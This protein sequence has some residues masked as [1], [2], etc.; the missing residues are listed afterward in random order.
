MAS[1]TWRLEHAIQ[2]GNWTDT[3]AVVS[4]IAPRLVGD[5]ASSSTPLP[6][7]APGS[8]SNSSTHNQ[9]HPRTSYSDSN[10]S[11]RDGGDPNLQPATRWT[12]GGGGITG[13]ERNVFVLSGGVPLLLQIFSDPGFTQRHRT[14]GQAESNNTSTTS[15][16]NLA[17]RYTTTGHISPFPTGHTGAMYTDARTL[18]EKYVSSKLATCWNEVLAVLREFVFHMPEIIEQLVCAHRIFPEHRKRNAS[19]KK[20]RQLEFVPWLFTLLSHDSCFDAA[21][22]LIEEIVSLQSQ[23]MATVSAEDIHCRY[24]DAAYEINTF[25]ISSSSVLASYWSSK[26]FH[27]G[28]VTNLYQLWESFTC[29]QLAHFCRILALLVFEPEDRQLLESPT[30]IKS[31]DMLRLRRERAARAGVRYHGGSSSYVDQNQSIVLGDECLMERLIQL[32]KIMNYAP[33]LHRVGPYR[34]MAHFP[35]IADTLLMLGLTE[36]ENWDEINRLDTLARS[37]TRSS[38][39]GDGREAT[40]ATQT[41]CNEE[42]C[43]YSGPSSLGSVAEMFEALTG[44]VLDSTNGNQVTHL[45]QV[46]DIFNAAQAAGVIGGS[47]ESSRGSMQPRMIEASLHALNPHTY[48][49]TSRNTVT[50]PEDAANDMQFN[51]LLLAPYQV[52]VLF[53]ICTLLGG[54]RKIDAQNIWTKLG[55]GSVLEEMFDRLSWGVSST[56]SSEQQNGIHGP[57]CECNPESALRV[58]YLRLLHNYCDRDCCNYH[59]RRQLLSQEEYDYIFA[60]SASPGVLKPKMSGLVSKLTQTFM[61]EPDDS[62]YKFWVASCI[63]SFLRG[64]SPGEKH[65][66]AQSGLLQYLLR[67]VLS[68][69]FHCVGSPQT[70]FDLLGELCKAN[71]ES[72]GMLLNE[73]DEASFRRLLEVSVAN[74][75]DSNVFI[76]SLLITVGMNPMKSIDIDRTTHHPVLPPSSCGRGYLTH[77]WWDH[78]MKTVDFVLTDT[79]S[80][81]SKCFS[82]SDNESLH[83]CEWFLPGIQETEKKHVVNFTT[84]SGWGGERESSYFSAGGIGWNFSFMACHA[85]EDGR[86]PYKEARLARFLEMNQ[87]RLLWNLLGVVDL[88]NINHETICCLNTAVV[89]AVFACRRSQLASLVKEL[90]CLSNGGVVNDE[91][92]ESMNEGTLGDRANILRSFRELLWFW[93]EYYT[94][95]GR[96]RLSLEFSSKIRFH[97]WKGVVGM[98]CADD[99]SITSLCSN[100]GVLPRSP[101]CHAPRALEGRWIH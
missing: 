100:S 83:P 101:Y 99:G 43:H 86:V 44:T 21:A 67:D 11:S 4:R 27:L 79:G 29:R 1:D 31:L 63:E 47:P 85:A 82:G 91:L 42:Q 35:W 74:L 52:E 51:A 54:R 40:S 65:F 13:F 41:Q 22:T 14:K 98:L 19:R 92:Y 8:S 17:D 55:L 64:S 71:V 30:V 39:Q 76:R 9:Q 61:R 26:I 58:Q 72:L 32:L 81:T 48:M 66:V 96:D 20:I 45:G 10:R 18:P 68:D 60:V 37:R 73:L 84:E 87:S 80:M 28:D 88:Q 70:S 50:Y 12:A 23:A 7:Y 95:R 59:G 5:I 56:R 3:C 38:L 62:P 33:D 78:P 24:G 53:V 25:S 36:L 2:T 77:S 57:G 90:G 49:R 34:I 16:G 69:R 75:V 93:T 6:D 89:I 97:E 15:T 46:I 94:Q